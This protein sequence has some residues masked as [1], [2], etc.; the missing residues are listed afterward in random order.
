MSSSLY[1]PKRNEMNYRK[2]I[3]ALI[4]LMLLWF[5]SPA[6]AFAD[7]ESSP[8]GNPPQKR[9]LDNGLT[10][11][12]QKDDSSAI[13]VIYLLIRGGKKAEPAGKDGLAHLVARLA[14]EIPDRG[15]IQ[16]LMNLATHISMNARG[17]YSLIRITCLSESLE[18]ILKIMAKIIKDPL[19]SGLRI[20]S[21]KDNMEYQRKRVE[22]DPRN[23]AYQ[24]FL[25]NL[26]AEKGY[27]GY[28]LGSKES[29]KKIKK[30]DIVNFYR[31]TF[32]GSNMILAV[33][34]NLEEEKIFNICSE[35]FTEFPEGTPLE[36]EPE[37]LPRKTEKDIFIAKDTKQSSVSIGFPLPEL[38]PRN[39]VLALL[40][41]TLLGKGA[42]SRLWPLRSQEKLAYVVDC[43]TTQMKK[44]GFLEAYLETDHTKKEK[45]MA[46]LKNELEKLFKEGLSEEELEMT[47]VQ[48]KA[49]FLRVNETKEERMQNFAVIEALGLGYE[50]LN[51][52]FKK[53]DAVVLEEMNAYIKD[54]LN[55]EKGV[56][57]VVGP[58]VEAKN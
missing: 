14:I 51:D 52:I 1:Y 41:E 22:D 49:S 26:L 55:P 19:F 31:E 4:I 7:Q 21:I 48:A 43:K 44:G 11:L 6:L 54:I 18:E 35:Y 29:L 42:G 13:T 34:S 25:D 24:A 20:D 47:K 33:S 50:F 17:D 37:V 28:I 36:V 53:I 40:L 56:Q 3:Y 12:Y 32:T 10:W 38:T 58:E 9:T 15:K 5:L 30:D 57:V 27:G 8:W 46:A 23:L 2:R 39:F 16:S 45:A